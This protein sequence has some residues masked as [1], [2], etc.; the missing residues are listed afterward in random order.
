MST[1]NQTHSPTTPP[2]TTPAAAT[3]PLYAA[4][5]RP[6]FPARQADGRWPAPTARPAYSAEQEGTWQ[7]LWSRQVPNLRRH[8]VA[9]FHEGLEHCGFSEAAI[10]SLPELS[11]RLHEATGW[12]LVRVE[13]LVPERPFFE[14]VR[15]RCFPCTDFIRRRDDLDYTPAPDLFHDQFGHVPLLTLPAFARFFERF[16]VAGCNA[17]DQGAIELARIYWFTVEFGLMREGGQRKA[18]GAG[19]MSSIG[20]LH[21][22]MSDDVEVHPLDFEAVAARPFVTT[23]IQTDYYEIESF[24]ALEAGFAAF[25]S[26]RGWL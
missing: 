20:E 19:L 1:P 3:P 4:E 10:P 26:A 25:A 5:T 7:L 11:A 9:A 6:V 8:A 15:E 22:G 2:P 24:E 18:F 23:E 16:G 21:H 17:D 13:G 14:M 12:R